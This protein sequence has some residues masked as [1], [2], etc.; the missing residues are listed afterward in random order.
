[1]IPLAQ[2]LKRRINKKQ[3]NITGRPSIRRSF[4]IFH[5]GFLLCAGAPLCNIFLLGIIL[6]AGCK[7]PQELFYRP[8][9][10]AVEVYET[11][12]RLHITVYPAAREKSAG[13]VI[14]IHGGGWR[15]GGSD[16]PL[17]QDWENE[18]R[19]RNLRAFSIEHRTA[20]AARGRD[21]I[22]D[23][24]KAVQYIQNNADRFGIPPRRIAL[25]GFSSGGHLAVM[26]A[27]FLSKNIPRRES[28]VRSVVSFYAPLDPAAMFTSGDENIHRL[29]LNYLPDSQIP[30]DEDESKSREAFLRRA[31]MDI[32][33]VDNLH[34]ACPPSLLIHGDSDS[35]VPAEQSI[36]FANAAAGRNIRNVTLQIVKGAEHNFNQSRNG[37]ARNEEKRALDFIINNFN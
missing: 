33:P 5:N 27:L 20:P 19:S 7:S 22:E 37:W 28:A 2:A 31:L 3:A 36:R 29:L 10:T 35:L 17:F 23:C 15:I 13:A 12:S 4:L 1:M 26:T 11:V 30:D 25:V 24:I 8:P 16:I 21:Q 9:G 34:T 18:L 14:F 32:S 6:L